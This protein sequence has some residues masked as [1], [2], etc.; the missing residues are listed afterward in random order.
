MK[1][2]LPGLFLNLATDMQAK[3]HK[4]SMVISLL[5][6]AIYGIAI[7]KGAYLGVRLHQIAWVG[8]GLSLLVTWLSKNREHHEG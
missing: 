7:F 5:L 8:I 1:S 2:I 6:L 4:Y 3:I